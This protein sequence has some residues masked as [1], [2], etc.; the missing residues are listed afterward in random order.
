MPICNVACN[1]H[2]TYWMMQKHIPDKAI[3]GMVMSFIAIINKRHIQD[4][5]F[6]ASTLLSPALLSRKYNKGT[7]ANRSLGLNDV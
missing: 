5:T 1:T 3:S 2:S 4:I 6:S 7:T